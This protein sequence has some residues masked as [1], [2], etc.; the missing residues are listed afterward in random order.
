MDHVLHPT[1]KESVFVTEIYHQD[2]D[3]KHQG[4]YNLLIMLGVVYNEMLSRENTEPDL[5]D[6]A[7]RKLLFLNSTTYS[8]ESGGKTSEIMNLRNSECIDFHKQFYNADQVCRPD[9]FMSFID[10]HTFNRSD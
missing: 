9:P 1:L 4:I 10:Y 2:G 5:L 8:V 7:L 6:L 3:A